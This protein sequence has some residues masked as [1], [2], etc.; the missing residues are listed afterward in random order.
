[1]A[2]SPFEGCELMVAAC[3]RQEAER[4]L[5]DDHHVVWVGNRPAVMLTYHWPR[6]DISGEPPPLK[7]EF[8][9]PVLHHP[10]ATSD[11]GTRR[12]PPAGAGAA[13]DG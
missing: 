10:A 8:G 5:P 9:A 13:G 1:M 6:L 2:R 4:L 7:L 11:P 12:A 3:S